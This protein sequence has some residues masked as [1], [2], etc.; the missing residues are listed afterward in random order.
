VPGGP[1]RPDVTLA[2]LRTWAVLLDARFR[3][4]GTQI[5]FGID[6]LLALI[7]GIG[8]LASPV[9]TTLL[10]VQGLHQRV[11][12]VIL[13]RMLGNAL[14]DALIGVVPVAGPVG[15]VFW[16]ANVRN[17]ALLERYARPG[18]APTRSDYVFV[19]AIVAV[20]GMI[21]VVPVAL[22]IWLTSL[23]LQLMAGPALR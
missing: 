16:K 18:L 20:F 2:W 4:P 10:I 13:V 6:P 8:D 1:V 15:D 5:R 19:F 7:P 21:V 3:I 12:K 23:F 9:F 22:A 14:L 11:P 17:L